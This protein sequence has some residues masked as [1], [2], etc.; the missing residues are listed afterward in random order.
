MAKHCKYID[1]GTRTVDGAVIFHRLTGGRG[2]PTRCLK[3]GSGRYVAYRP[4]K[5]VEAAEAAEAS[6]N[7]AEAVA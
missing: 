1:S 4:T 6:T 7:A 5:V 2:R 3:N